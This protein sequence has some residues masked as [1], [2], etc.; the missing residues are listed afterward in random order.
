VPKLVLTVF[1]AALV[2]VLDAGRNLAAASAHD[3]LTPEERQVFE[4]VI[5]EY[6]LNNP[7]V[8]LEVLSILRE[9]ERLAA[10]QQSRQQLAV[11]RDDLLNDP[12]SPVGGNP[13][14][15]VTI[16]EFFDYRCPYCRNVAPRLAQLLEEDKGI[17]FVYK[18][19]PIL[20]PVSEVAA[21]AALA[22]REQGRYEAFHEAL[23]TYPG[24]LTED[25]V[26]QL[27]GR[28]GLDESRLRQDME[29][30]EIEESLARTRALA[31]A[32][33]ITG[34][35]AFIIGDRLI[36]GAVSLTD[37]RTLVKRAREKS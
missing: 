26:F 15:D 31:T 3:G 2:L 32:L 28:V 37:L 1:L 36:P 5:R 17:R 29:A 11:R 12:D 33:G 34:T 8:I 23:M 10:A 30:P 27:G 20:G 22:S 9:R 14:G 21:R 4:D 24:Q 18:E 19:W 35:P 6:L 16:V 7:D 13:E 25:T